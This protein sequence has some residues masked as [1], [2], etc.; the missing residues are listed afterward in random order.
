MKRSKKCNNGTMGRIC[1]AAVAIA[2]GISSH[3]LTE[4]EATTT[5]SLDSV[6][7][8]TIIGVEKLIRRADRISMNQHDITNV[9][10][11][12]PLDLRIQLEERQVEDKD[13][14]ITEENSNYMHNS[15]MTEYIPVEG[16]FEEQIWSIDN[17]WIS[18]DDVAVVAWDDITTPSNTYPESLE[19]ALKDTWLEGYG[20]LYY[21]L[22]QEYG[23]NALFAIG[24][25]FTEVG[26]D[27]KSE[28]SLPYTSRN[29]IYGIQ[30]QSFASYEECIRYYFDFMNRLYVKEGIIDAKSVSQK[31]CPPTPR[32]WRTTIYN[33]ECKLKNKILETVVVDADQD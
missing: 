27:D 28:K 12:N 8:M 11:S 20:T 13:I 33:I 3:T 6:D 7:M 32:S 25:A 18:L 22:E 21:E 10:S 16:T 5:P 2:V 14:S 9:E 30:N 15:I 19:F 24:N 29:N 31:Y 1:A 26:W 23:I 17:G 4:T